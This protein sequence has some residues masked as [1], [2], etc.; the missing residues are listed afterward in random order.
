ML[1]HLSKYDLI[2]TPV[3]ACHQMAHGESLDHI[4]GF[5]YT[6]TF[7]LTGWPA[8]VVRAG[9]SK[10]DLP[11]GIQIAATSWRED[12]VLAA[13]SLVEQSIGGWQHPPI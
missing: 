4:L 10:D 7:N 5:S 8:G 13:L 3:N 9:T 1:S 11:I 2:L 12:I 6:A